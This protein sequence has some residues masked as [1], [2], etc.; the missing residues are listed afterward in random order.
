MP[1]PAT[2]RG[3]TDCCA[4]S[5]CRLRRRKRRA[6]GEPW[7]VPSRAAPPHGAGAKPDCSRLGFVP[8]EIGALADRQAFQ[9][10]AQAIKA[11]LDRSQAH[12]F[13][14]AIDARPARG[15]PL[16]GGDRKVDAATEID[17]VG[18]VIDR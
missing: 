10:A 6:P 17:A 12:P 2:A 15:D 14:P 4:P 16:F 8:L 5:S 1:K 13:A 11:K 18:T 3:R 7:A 9:I